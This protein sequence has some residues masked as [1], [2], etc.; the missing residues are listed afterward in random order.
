MNM[1]NLPKKVYFKRGSMNVA[2]KELDEVYDL[3]RAFII[4]DANLYRA[5]AAAPVIDW[6]RNRGIRCAEFFTLSEVP[7]FAD[8]KSGLPKMLEFEPDV[9]IAVG[10]GSVISAAKAMWI[11]YE[12]PEVDLADVAAKFNTLTGT[13]VGF[14]VTGAKAKLVAVPT[15]FGTGAQNSPFAVLADDAGKKVV[16]ASYKLLPEI[17]VTDAIFADSMSADLIKKSASALL[18]LVIRAF[19]APG[20]NAYTQGLLAEVVKG[21]VNNTEAAANGCPLAMEKLANAGA[22]AGFAVGNAVTTLDP[23][24][25]VYPTKQEK[26]A[27]DASVDKLAK[28]AGLADSEA[29]IA[30]C[31]KIAAL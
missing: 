29:L 19:I 28:L 22:I 21:V 20:S 30:A 5:G 4:S 23:N 2:L 13:D 8:V 7:T 10:G 27:E 3:K 15:T 11:Q 31:E 24:A 6:L 9:I 16:I 1:L 12:N 18:S 26:G 14:P 17:S 25:E